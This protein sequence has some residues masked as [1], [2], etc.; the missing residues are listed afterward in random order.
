LT[1]DLRYAPESAARVRQL[2]EQER[3]CCTFLQFD[4]QESAD[5]VD[6]RISREEIFGPVVPVIPFDGE[7]EAIRL[8]NDS[9]RRRT[10]APKPWDSASFALPRMQT[11]IIASSIGPNIQICSMGRESFLCG[12]RTAL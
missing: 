1:L 7:D 2:V 4:L 10:S 12:H 3:T 8:A 9:E 5:E 11:V 6:M